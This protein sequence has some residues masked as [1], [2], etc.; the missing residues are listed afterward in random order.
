MGRTTH[1]KQLSELKHKQDLIEKAW[2]KRKGNKELLIFLVDLMPKAL[3]AERCSI[4]ILDPFKKDVWVHCGTGLDEKKV[5]V[6]MNNSLA[7][8]VIDSGIVIIEDNMQEQVG[9]HDI[10]AMKTGFITHNVIC[11]PVFGVT[12]KRTTG[13]IQV[14]NKTINTQFSTSDQ[15]SLERLAFLL[16]MNIENIF[17]RQEL[18]RMLIAMKKQIDFL[19]DKIQHHGLLGLRR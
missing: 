9:A 8:R 19:E 6:P 11:V 14:L 5:S 15:K 7:G 16:Q 17:I 4:F 18:G 13:A 12:Q 2:K 10:I 3:D 1:S